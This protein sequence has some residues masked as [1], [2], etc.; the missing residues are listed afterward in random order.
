MG[1]CILCF[2]PATQQHHIIP[3]SR[4]DPEVYDVDF[5]LVDLCTECH[6]KVHNEGPMR[7]AERLMIAKTKADSI[8]AV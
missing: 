2:R 4:G 7:W 3:K 6:D 1:T 5:N 8:L